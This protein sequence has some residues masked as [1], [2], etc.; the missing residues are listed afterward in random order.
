MGRWVRASGAVALLSL[1]GVFGLTGTAGAVTT[2]CGGGC[3]EIASAAYAGTRLPSLFVVAN[4]GLP[5]V[6]EPIA[7]APPNVS[8]P[9]EDFTE[10]YQ[11]TVSDFIQ[12]GLINP[13]MAAYDSDSAVEFEYA[14]NG[15]GSELCIGIAP[16]W[17]PADS[18][19]TL[20]DCGVSART[21]WI[22]VQTTIPTFELLNGAS[23]TAAAPGALTA[24]F[25]GLPLLT[26]PLNPAL[27]AG[28]QSI[29]KWRS[30]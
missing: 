16:P 25:P 27:S 7:L 1:L 6:G 21:V 3:V 12:A 14:P 8:N 17:S 24:L 2:S 15:I 4:G 11:G 28:T 20:Q 5:E 29:Q 26:L 23:A 9:A 18:M 19:V 13:A 30:L 10:S 22:V